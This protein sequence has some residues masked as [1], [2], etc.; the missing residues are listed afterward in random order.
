MA[1]IDATKA[2]GRVCHVKLFK[3]LVE[4]NVPDCLI[5]VPCDWYDRLYAVVR[6]NGVTNHMFPVKCGVRHGGV[7]SPW[8]FNIYKIILTT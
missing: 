4:R 3:K 1:A 6:W 2:F 8:L 5:A 7:L